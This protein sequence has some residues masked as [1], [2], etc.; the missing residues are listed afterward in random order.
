MAVALAACCIGCSKGDAGA[1]ASKSNQ[2]ADSLRRCSDS[3]VEA[4]RDV[5]PHRYREYFGEALELRRRAAAIDPE[6]DSADVAAIEYL[7]SRMQMLDTLYKYQS[8]L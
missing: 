7:E 2:T 1:T 8:E 6:A 3:L 5:P 4:A